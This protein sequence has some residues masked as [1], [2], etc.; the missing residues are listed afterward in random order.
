M[1]VNHGESRS[2]DEIDRRLDEVIVAFLECKERGEEPDPRRLPPHDPEELA[3]LTELV[4]DEQAL[5]PWFAPLRALA[6][7]GVGQFLGDY[8]LLE[9]IGVGGQGV[10]YR[11]RQ[12]HGNKEVALK[13]IN[14]QDRRRSLRELEMAANL[15]HEHLVRVYH[16]GEHA[17]RLY[18]TMKL[19]EKGKLSEHVEEYSLQLTRAKTAAERKGVEERQ[20]KIA[21][22][23]AKIAR[24]VHYI[25]EQRII[26]RDLK[27][28]NV[29]LDA[30]DEPLVSDHGLARRV[31]DV[32]VEFAATDPAPADE[33]NTRGASGTP[34]Y[35]APE[36]ARK[37]LPPGYMAPEQT[38]GAADL[39]RAVD[40][41]GL[42]A[43]LY[44]LLTGR[45]PFEGTKE[46]M[47]AQT[48]DPERVVTPPSLYNPNLP[49]GS[50]LELICRKCLR[51]QPDKRYASA[52]VLAEDLE[53]CVRGEPTSVRPRS[54]WEECMR[55][56]VGAVNHKLSIPGITRWGAIDL[57][58]AG[59]N[60]A[61]NV[62]LFAL[63]R[64]D[65]PPALLW[66]TLLTF[67]VV[68][69][70]MFLTFLFRH[71]AI[72]PTERHLALLWA[73]VYL[74][75]LTLAWIYCPPFGPAR[76]ADLL[77]YYPPWTVV[78]GL[79][80]LVVGRLYWGRYYAVGLAHFLVA[81]LMPLW[82]DLAPLVYGGFVAVFMTASAWQHYR[83]AYREEPRS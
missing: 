24:A 47:I 35:M 23:L 4:E 79:A 50:D 45:T 14:P 18:F 49:T 9:V 64:T 41:Y 74:A 27:P 58:D 3:A 52:A 51:K 6:Q 42:G 60:L 46:E 19:A 70:W 16:V 44:K 8:E 38:Q 28:G 71:K 11:A 72:E 80:F 17:G 5:D 26:N 56:V 32:T 29:L 81:A 68:W 55:A 65:Q 13:L 22:L 63:I 57:C 10:V 48:A 83:T 61:A 73:G 30:R 67:L 21:G 54:L 69:W 76:A 20:H 25:H 34:G 43:T 36:Q 77:A 1:D 2:R 37:A 82:P 59:L 33:E 15:E 62:L 66:L 53:R 40:I 39:T 12:V 78:N 31:R 7:A 75:G